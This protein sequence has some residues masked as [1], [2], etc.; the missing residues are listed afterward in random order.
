MENTNVINQSQDTRPEELKTSFCRD[1]ENCTACPT[2]CLLYA[3][4]DMSLCKNFFAEN[5]MKE[6][7]LM[8]VME[9]VSSF[10]SPDCKDRTLMKWKELRQNTDYAI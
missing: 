10:I 8:R 6:V 9:H 7:E 3:K 4:G 5:R 1:C 2:G